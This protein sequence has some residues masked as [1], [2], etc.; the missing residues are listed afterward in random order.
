[1][2]QE[3]G[4]PVNQ[5]KNAG[6]ES[7][8]IG[9]QTAAGDSN[10]NWIAQAEHWYAW[11]VLSGRIACSLEGSASEYQIHSRPY[12]SVLGSPQA[13]RPVPLQI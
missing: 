1:M 7:M 12:G 9:Q 13:L 8:E 2:T 4:V 10:L 3:P 11:K 5:K 6:I